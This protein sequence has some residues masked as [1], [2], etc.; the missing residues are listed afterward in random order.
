[1]T[2]VTLGAFLRVRRSSLVPDNDDLGAVSRRRVPGL[3]REEVAQRVGVSVDY[4]T[5]LEQGRRAAP[6]EGVLNALADVLRL[7]DPAREHMRDLAWNNSRPKQSCDSTVQQ[8]RP[9]ML[10]LLESFGGLPAVLVGRRIDVLATSP[11]ARLLIADFNAMPAQERNAVRWVLLSERARQSHVDWEAAAAGLV[12]MLRMDAGRHP[13][14][15]RTAELIDE[16]SETSEHF[17]KLWNDCHV[18]TSVVPESKVLQHPVVGRIRL[19]VEA[20]TTP[21]D[22]DQTL[23]VMIPADLASQSAIQELQTLAGVG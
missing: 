1:M 11:T 9:G 19:H 23:H 3:R 21:R 14:D 22:R 18:A 10:R 15:P 16:L 7:D 12:G 20:V 2:E 13:N 4:Y 6:S 5:K 17:T 8:A